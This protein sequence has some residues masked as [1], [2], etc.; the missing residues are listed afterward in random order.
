MLRA[1]N[2]PWED[3]YFMTHDTNEAI[4]NLLS[5]EIMYKYLYQGNMQFLL[6]CNSSKN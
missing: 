2:F 4:L 5:K 1:W 3:I 6:S